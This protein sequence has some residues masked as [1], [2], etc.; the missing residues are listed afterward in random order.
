MNVK[1]SKGDLKSTWSVEVAMTVQK[2]GAWVSC[3]ALF[4][5]SYT[6]SETCNRLLSV[7]LFSHF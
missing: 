7:V 5:T 1:S 3:P 4:Y 2:S 6:G